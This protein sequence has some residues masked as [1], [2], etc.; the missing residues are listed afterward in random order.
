MTSKERFYAKINGVKTICQF[1]HI[2]I[3]CLTV[4]TLSAC[5][6]REHSVVMD[7][8]ETPIQVELSKKGTIEKIIVNGK[9][10]EGNFNAE[11]LLENCDIFLISSK[12]EENGHYVSVKTAKNIKTGNT[13]T[14]TEYIY[15]TKNSIRWEM[16]IVGE[17]V[18][19]S[20][21]IVT[22][23]NYPAN[24]NVKYWTAWGRPQ[25]EVDKL[26][27]TVLKKELKLM[28]DTINN[29]LNPLVPVPFTNSQY[30][31][32]A[33]YVTYDNPELVF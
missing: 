7:N 24:E 31:Y 27:D 1:R 9:K 28:T 10:I 4:L 2:V 8:T 20:T 13:C 33:P 3:C 14:I 17:K 6:N 21:P 23:I 16:E 19:W 26:K 11:T 12:Q 32:G 5:S 25:I 30:F 18:P 15:P 22:S 29:W